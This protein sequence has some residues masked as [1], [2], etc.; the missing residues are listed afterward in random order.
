[1]AEGAFDVPGSKAKT[2]AAPHIR[3]C[4]TDDLRNW[5]IRE[6]LKIT[7]PHCCRIPRRPWDPRLRSVRAAADGRAQA[8]NGRVSDG[9]GGRMRGCGSGR[10][11]RS[12]GVR[13]TWRRAGS[14]WSVPT[15][16]DAS[17]VPNGGRPSAADDASAFALRATADRARSALRKT[18]SGSGFTPE[19]RTRTRKRA[20]GGVLTKSPSTRTS[21][22]SEPTRTERGLG[23]PRES[24]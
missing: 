7:F 2:A 13:S 3:Q 16:R 5:L 11:S 15:G 17:T 8:R 4:R 10:S 24:V 6:D 21:A 1:M 19:H 14:P 12:N 20:K 9:A 18:A 23:P 22:A